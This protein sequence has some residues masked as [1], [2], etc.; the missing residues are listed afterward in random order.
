MNKEQRQWKSDGRVDR[1]LVCMLSSLEIRSELSM[2][3][4]SFVDVVLNSHMKMKNSYPE[5]RKSMFKRKHLWCMKQ[6]KHIAVW[7]KHQT[8]Y[9]TAVLFTYAARYRFFYFIIALFPVLFI[10]YLNYFCF[11]AW[12]FVAEMALIHM[13]LAQ[14]RFHCSDHWD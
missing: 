5:S 4:T 13:F 2:I 11:H 9:G 1:T 12:N 10:V 7:S 3:V 6:P 14:H 8:L